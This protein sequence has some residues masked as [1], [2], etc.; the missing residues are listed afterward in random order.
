MSVAFY[1]THLDKPR[2]ARSEAPYIPPPDWHRRTLQ[3]LLTVAVELPEQ[4]E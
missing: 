4:S 1:V 3:S 2:R